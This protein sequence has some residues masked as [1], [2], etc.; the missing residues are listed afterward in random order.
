[1]ALLA[2]TI[3]LPTIF[4]HAAWTF[5][6]ETTAEENQQIAVLLPLSGPFADLGKALQVGFKHG[7]AQQI[8]SDLINHQFK[9]RFHQR[10]DGHGIRY[11]LCDAWG[12]NH[13]RYIIR[14]ADLLNYPQNLYRF[15]I[16]GGL[17]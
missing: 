16:K 17:C 3:L 14:I 12:R 9:I 11:H 6:L 5:E 2:L 10:F 7:F 15:K 13:N 4:P 8:E 1:M